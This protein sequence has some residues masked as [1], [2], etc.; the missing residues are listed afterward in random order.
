[1][2][3]RSGMRPF[4][5][6]TLIFCV[7]CK[8]NRTQKE[9]LPSTPDTVA[10]T[11]NPPT[12]QPDPAPPV[13][14]PPVVAEPDPVEKICSKLD[15]QSVTWPSDLSAAEH[16]YYALALN[17]T[18][19]FEG[20]V[21]WKNIAGNFD[22]QGISLGLMQQ[23]LG[24]G[25]LQPLL[26]NMY[27]RQVSTMLSNFNSSQFNSMKSML[28]TW[29]ND[30]I[31]SLSSRTLAS[32]DEGS[33]EEELF[34][35]GSAFNNL[36]EGYEE[37]FDFLAANNNSKSVSWARSTALDSSGNVTATWKKSFQDMAVSAPYRSQQIAASTKYFLK[38]KAYF[39]SLGFK[40]L[41]HLLLMYDI[42]VQNGSI[43]EQHLKIY[44]DW[45]RSHSKAS[46]EEKALALLEARLTTVK[47]QYKADVRSRKTTII[48]GVGSVHQTVRN[49]P[50]EY[51][52]DPRV[53]TD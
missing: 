30:D 31:M 14:Q 5:I 3:F 53:I 19:S 46:E 32:L 7:S 15:F 13:V 45:L 24:Q 22:G 36:D 25:T 33:E 52:F 12:N 17:I 27:R 41:R 28:E 26:I 9:T 49:L 40:E 6:L 2:M 18:G 34:P 38:A 11:P 50:Q 21:G 20:N 48:K 10:D 8:Q 39:T 35:V 51:C 4:I 47:D 43:G 16:V 37:K 23:N 42:V 29:L 1:M 44:Q